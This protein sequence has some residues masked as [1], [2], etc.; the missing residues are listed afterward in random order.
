MN[1]HTESAVDNNRI[2]QLANAFGEH[3]GIVRELVN[4]LQRPTR[5]RLKVAEVELVP[6]ISRSTVYR[7]IREGHLERADV[8]RGTRVTVAS[9]EQYVERAISAARAKNNDTKAA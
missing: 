6:S 9:V 7:L 4:A 5:Y 1:T 3:R 2:A 8:D